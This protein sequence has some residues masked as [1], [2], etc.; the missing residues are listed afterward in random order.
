M[1]WIG[2][3]ICYKQFVADASYYFNTDDTGHGAFLLTND[4]YSWHHSDNSI[5][6]QIQNVSFTTN[7]IVILTLD[8]KRKILKF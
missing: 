3:G 2:I 5:N 8:P 7:D 6:S 1:S 4:G